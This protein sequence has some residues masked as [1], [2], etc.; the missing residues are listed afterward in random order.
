MVFFGQ[1]GEG[2]EETFICRIYNLKRK[3]IIFLYAVLCYQP[4]LF[5]VFAY[6]A[7]WCF[8]W[9]RL[10]TSGC[11]WP[12]LYSYEND[13]LNTFIRVCFI[14]FSFKHFVFDCFGITNVQ[15]IKLLCK[16]RK[17]ILEY[18]VYA[19]FP[20]V[21]SYS[22]QFLTQYLDINWSSSSN[23]HMAIITLHC[24]AK[25]WTHDRN[26]NFLWFG[27]CCTQT[28]KYYWTYFWFLI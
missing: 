11:T 14:H 27:A 4:L 5:F 3:K 6:R 7:F 28:A 13:I 24:R 20:T 21:P 25:V 26:L 9:K 17:G 19:G 16:M 1:I 8:G 15:K 18:G 2:A 23:T 10:E 12:Y 22:I